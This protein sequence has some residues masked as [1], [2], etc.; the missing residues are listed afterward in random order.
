MSA[1]K[2]SALEQES[3]FGDKGAARRGTGG[4]RVGVTKERTGV[5]GQ[6]CLSDWAADL[7]VNETL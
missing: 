6:L 7:H 3:C 1:L 2:V 5:G 4:L